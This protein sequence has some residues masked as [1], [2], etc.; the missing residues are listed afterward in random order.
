MENDKGT[1]DEKCLLYNVYTEPIIAVV[2]QRIVLHESSLDQ[3]KTPLFSQDKMKKHSYSRK[4]NQYCVTFNISARFL[5]SG[6][7]YNISVPYP[8]RFS[9]FTSVLTC[10]CLDIS[11]YTRSLD[12]LC[13]YS[14]NQGYFYSTWVHIS[15]KSI[16]DAPQQQHR[17]TDGWQQ[18]SGGQNQVSSL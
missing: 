5:L 1:R 12:M 16:R 13:S 9:H 3:N 17:Q 18:Y 10:L 7:V 2:Q 4:R 6:S 8:V 15:H 11:V 14:V